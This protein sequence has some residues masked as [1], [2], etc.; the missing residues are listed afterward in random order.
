MPI[1]PDDAVRLQAMLVEALRDLPGAT[2]LRAFGSLA[3]GDADHYSDIDLDLLATDLS[4]S[5]TTRHAVIEQVAPVWLEW[6]IHPSHSDWAATILFDGHSPYH[7]LDLGITVVDRP[8]SADALGDMVTLWTQAAA[9]P[10]IITDASAA[11]APAV[12][13]PGHAMLEQLLS[14]IRYAKA[15]KRSQILLAY[16]FASALATSTFA[17]LDAR[18]TGDLTHLRTRPSTSTV[19]GLDRQLPPDTRGDLVSLFDFSS[20]E[21]MDTAVL[22]LLR[23][24]LALHDA[25]PGTTI[26]PPNVATRLLAFLEAALRS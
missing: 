21:R 16:R 12:G 8:A 13:T 17:M 18:S 4:A 26:F 20:P 15:R 9:P 5:I 14:A 10:R 22:A 25:L 6:R 7:H 1:S 11:Y 19:L 24:N 3:Y 23:H 2:E